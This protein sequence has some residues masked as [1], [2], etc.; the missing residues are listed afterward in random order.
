MA[1]ISRPYVEVFSE[2]GPNDKA[3]FHAVSAILLTSC[4]TVRLRNM[5][6]DN[7]KDNLLERQIDLINSLVQPNA[8]VVYAIRYVSRPNRSFLSGGTIDMAIFCRWTSHSEDEARRQVEDQLSQLLIQL[9]ASFPDYIWQMVKTQEEFIKVWRPIDWDKAKVAEIRR[10]E[11]L[12]T[13]DSIK[14]TRRLGFNNYSTDNADVPQTNLYMVHPF[15]PHPGQLERLL[16]MIL[17]NP[18]RIV[19]TVTLSPVTLEDKEDQFLTDEISNSEGFRKNP[20]PNIQRIQEHRASMV[21]NALMD[22]LLSLQD[23][24]FYTTITLASPEKLP[25]TLVEAAGLAVSASVGEVPDSPY[26]RSAFIQMGGYDAVIPLTREEKEIVRDNL[27]TLS[28]QPW[29]QTLAP[30]DAKRLRYLMNGHESACAFRF[31]EDTGEGL[32]GIKTHTQRSRPIPLELTEKLDRLDA[33]QTLLMGTNSY[34]GL[35]NDI[36]L[37]LNDRLLHMYVVG[38][39]GTGKSTLLKTMLLSDMEAGRGCAL[40]DPHG[41]LYEEMLGLVPPMRVNDVILLDPSDMKFPFGMNLLEADTWEE[42]QFVVREMQAIMRRLMLEDYGRY[43]QEFAGPV[44]YQ[45]MAMNMLLVMSDPE[46]PGTLLDFYEVYQSND[47]WKRWIPLKT[48]DPQLK[49]WVE[50][51]LSRMDYLRRSDTGH[52]TWGEYLSSK[53]MDFVFDPRLRLIFGQPQST[54]NLQEIMNDGKILFINLAKGLLGE[55][56]SRFLGLILMAK[57]QAEAMKRGKLPPNKRRPFFLYVDEFQSLATENFSILLSE[58]RKFKLGLVLANQFLSQIADQSIIRAVFGN[59]GT[60]LSFRLGRED[61]GIVEPQFLPYFDQMDL[62]NMPNWQV[63][64]RTTV[65]G[66][67]L[68]PFSLNTILPAREYD[69]KIASQ[70]RTRSRVEHGKTREQVEKMISENLANKPPV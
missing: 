62:I 66:A 33:S 23:A 46:H 39:T 47:Y 55:A 56:N 10:R 44:F 16:R 41:D 25:A 54:F 20:S 29:G 3:N 34:M 48:E 22:Q 70:V 67:S 14:P 4:P 31:P 30:A 19:F 60:F 28:Q 69:P 12:V 15:L 38:Q 63:A 26:T 53:F 9:C 7:H 17:L 8:P 64:M 6:S 42:R 58:A 24:P 51:I 50:N 2:A 57:I 36:R 40:I 13:L 68:H 1:I 27:S 49:T 43:G 45:H 35:T 18:H 11:E 61:A 37:P 65:D 52:S 21:C 59:V 5:V 32:P